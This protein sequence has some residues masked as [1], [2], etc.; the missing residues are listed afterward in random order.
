MQAVLSRKIRGV[1][2]HDNACILKRSSFCELATQTVLFTKIKVVLF[3][4]FF[5]SF[6]FKV[7]S[8]RQ[9]SQNVFLDILISVMLLQSD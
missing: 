5:H 6:F 1:L 3:V 8:H 9:R 7:K 4:G 2:C